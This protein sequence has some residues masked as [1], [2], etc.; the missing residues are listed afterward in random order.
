MSVNKLSFLKK[1]VVNT[2]SLPLILVQL[3][4]HVKKDI[5]FPI[6]KFIIIKD[7]ILWLKGHNPFVGGFLWKYCKITIIYWKKNISR[8]FN[9]LSIVYF[10]IDLIFTKPH[11]I[12]N[13]FDKR[14]VNLCWKINCF[15]IKHIIFLRPSFE[16]IWHLNVIHL[17]LIGSI[18]KYRMKDAEDEIFFGSVWEKCKVVAKYTNYS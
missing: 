7:F 15:I 16:F 10:W 2:K 4:K 12:F 6:L 11:R 18:S 1:K 8:I 17:T 13:N 9:L 5:F 14:H 3:F